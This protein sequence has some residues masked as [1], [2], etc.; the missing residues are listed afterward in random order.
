MMRS[1]GSSS[2]IRGRGRGKAPMG[3]DNVLAQIENQK[4]IASNIAET[5]TSTSGIITEHPMY[6]KFMNFIQ[7]RQVQGTN[8]PSFSSAIT[9]EGNENIEVF[10]KNEKDEVILLEPMDLQWKDDPW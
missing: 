1:S 8:P 2:S 5:Y 6:K 3:R 9:D 4:L 7:F 10:D